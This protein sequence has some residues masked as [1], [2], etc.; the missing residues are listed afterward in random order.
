MK[1]SISRRDHPCLRV[2]PTSND[3]CPSKRQKK[4]H[5][6]ETRQ[7]TGNAKA[8]A[9]IEGCDSTSGSI[10]SRTKVEEARGDSRLEL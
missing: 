4:G 7:G 2:G 6:T 3:T 8:K 9:E 5:N 1:L 10:R